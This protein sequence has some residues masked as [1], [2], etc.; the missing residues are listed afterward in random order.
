MTFGTVTLTS[1]V[2]PKRRMDVVSA[3][4]LQ[5]DEGTAGSDEDLSFFCLEPVSGPVLTV[6]TV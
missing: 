5:V 1:S 4:S 3:V 6:V 2:G